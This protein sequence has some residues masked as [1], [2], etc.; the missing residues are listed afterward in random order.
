VRHSSST[1]T[2]LVL[3]IAVALVSKRFTEQVE[4][5]AQQVGPAGL[6]RVPQELYNRNLALLAGAA[7]VVGLAMYGYI[8]FYP[9]FL[10]KQLGFSRADAGSAASMFGLGALLGLP[11]GWLGTATTSGGS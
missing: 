8:G 11:A 1:A 6:D 4:T 10:Q 9:T 3:L 2:G 5:A 7:V